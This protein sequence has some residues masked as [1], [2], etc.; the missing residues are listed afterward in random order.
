MVTPKPLV[1]VAGEADV[2]GVLVGVLQAAAGCVSR[3]SGVS[4]AGDK[5]QVA[6]ACVFL[7]AVGVCLV[8]GG[9]AA[10]A[11]RALMRAWT[12]RALRLGLA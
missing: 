12:L 1:T 7:I 4:G 8:N 11:R 2:P 10:L 6:E 3:A 9:G 5:A